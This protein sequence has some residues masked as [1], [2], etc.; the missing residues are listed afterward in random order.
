MTEDKTSVGVQEME[1]IRRDVLARLKRI[2]GQVRGI[3]RML[4]EGEK[5]EATL[6]QVR[7][8]RNALHSVNGLIIRRYLLKCHV[9]A[10]RDNRSPGKTLGEALKTLA[11]YLDY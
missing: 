6:V 3:H 4:S 11:T 7:A 2:E 1:R 8:V 5:S 9:T 10:S